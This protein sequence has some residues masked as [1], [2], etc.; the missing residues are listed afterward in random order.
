MPISKSPNG[1]NWP[2][3][4]SR[5]K[6]KKF[7]MAKCLFETD[8]LLYSANGHTGHQRR[9]CAIPQVKQQRIHHSVFTSVYG[10]KYTCLWLPWQWLI[11]AFLFLT[12][13]LCSRSLRFSSKH[14]VTH[15]DWMNEGQFINL[16]RLSI[17]ISPRILWK[18][19]QWGSACCAYGASRQGAF[20]SVILYST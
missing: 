20:A 15:T 3:L 18:D 13:L 9:K 1:Q 2:M 16:V 10:I 5:K 8:V 7:K 14:L 4:L 19:I 17:L 12:L 6:K 11:F